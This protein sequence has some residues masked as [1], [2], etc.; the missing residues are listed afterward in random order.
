VV[1][2]PARRT[3]HRGTLHLHHLLNNI[4]GMKSKASVSTLMIGTPHVLRTYD[5]KDYKPRSKHDVV[6]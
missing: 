4:G 6:K 5:I 1:G 2:T 3:L